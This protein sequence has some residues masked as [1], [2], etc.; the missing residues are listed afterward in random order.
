MNDALVGISIGSFRQ[1]YSVHPTFR[2]RDILANDP[3]AV[4]APTIMDHAYA[5]EYTQ[6]WSG[7]SILRRLHC[8]PRSRL[9]GRLGIA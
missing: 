8:L 2:T 3:T 6:T 4:V 1:Q 7:G 5:V 9:A